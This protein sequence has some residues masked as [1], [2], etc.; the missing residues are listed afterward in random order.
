MHHHTKDK[1]DLGL[2]FV[3]AD[4]LRQG[5]QPAILLSEHLPFDCLAISATG[6]VKKLSVKYRSL[7][8]GAILVPLR[9]SWADRH[10]VHIQR[11]DL[12][13][14]D[15]IAVYCPNNSKVYYIRSNEL[16]EFKCNFSLRVE[17]PKRRQ[18]NE[19][20]NATEYEKAARIFASVAQ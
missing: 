10:G 12:S 13:C 20:R 4:L 17:Q 2:G 7:K 6:D 18:S 5:C 15:A 9:S 1:G 14:V 8:N 11:S 19:T 3:I 16:S